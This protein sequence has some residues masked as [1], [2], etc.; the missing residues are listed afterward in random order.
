MGNTHYP[1]GFYDSVRL[2]GRAIENTLC[3]PNTESAPK[4]S[5]ESQSGC[6]KSWT[7]GT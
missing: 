2:F 6:H 4:P 1:T 5:A 7:N 3:Q